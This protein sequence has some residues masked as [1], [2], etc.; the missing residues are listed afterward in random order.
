MTSSLPTAITS[1]TDQSLILPSFSLL[2]SSVGLH[3]RLP[4]VPLLSFNFSSSVLLIANKTDL[5]NAA[6][7]DTLRAALSLDE[8]M[9]SRAYHIQPAVASQGKGLKEGL[10]WLAKNMKPNPVADAEPNGNDDGAGA[11]AGPSGASSAASSS[12]SS[13][14]SSEKKQ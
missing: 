1:F 4:L 11:G 14:G 13:S 3:H 9:G 10:L 7:G 2:L 8:L 5:P 12:S 6:S